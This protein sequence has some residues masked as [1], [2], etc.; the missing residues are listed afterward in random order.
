M[1]TQST[2]PAEAPIETQQDETLLEAFASICSVLVIGLFVITFIFQNYVIPSG[3]MEKT[4]LVGDHVFVDRMT[5][6]PPTKWFPLI[7]YRDPHVGDII[8]FLKPHP[9]QPD[10]VLVKRVVGVPG[11]RIHLQA[12]VLYRNGVRQNEPQISMPG[13]GF[14]Y[15]PFRDD[16]PSQAPDNTIDTQ[17]P[18][19]WVV[20]F[21]NHLVNGELV[22]PPGTVF[23][24][25]DNRTDSLDGRYWGFV[26]RENIMGRPLFNY[27][28]FVTPDDQMDKTSIS[29]RITFMFHILT[30][31][32][33]DT[34]WSRTFHP[35]K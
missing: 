12:G 27:W 29:D 8:V 25:G 32:V 6:A 21:P 18:S 22:V 11:D 9:E 33:S 14:P 28:S 23:A 7:H 35:I 24:M 31:F 20:D 17:I 3:S 2:T 10:L 4:L 16:F 26:P 30:H 13:A 1:T 19:A 34:R 5:F 15:D